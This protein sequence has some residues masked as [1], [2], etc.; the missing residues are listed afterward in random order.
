MDR[1]NSI[2]THTIKAQTPNGATLPTIPTIEGVHIDVHTQPIATLPCE[3]APFPTKPTIID[4]GGYVDTPVPAA[5][6][7]PEVVLRQFLATTG[8]VAYPWPGPAS[9]L[10]PWEPWGTCSVGPV[11]LGN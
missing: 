2:T 10:G 6:P 1:R 5:H 4:V 3:G 7:S 9:G 8:K 11:E